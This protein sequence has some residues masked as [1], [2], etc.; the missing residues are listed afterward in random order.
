MFRKAAI[1]LALAASFLGAQAMD[2]PKPV[3]ELTH[4]NK[5]K[6][7]AHNSGVKSKT[8]TAQLCLVG[9]GYD[10]MG[11]DSNG[12]AFAATSY[13]YT[14]HM[15]VYNCA[16]VGTTGAPNTGATPIGRLA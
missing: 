10:R 12:G 15:S 3:R 1:V 7:A 8:K 2:L 14:A 9:E 16:D 13:L 4:K 11:L 6:P 5:T